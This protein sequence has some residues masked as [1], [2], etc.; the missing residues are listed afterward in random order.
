MGLKFSNLEKAIFA[1]VKAGAGGMA[2]TLQAELCSLGDCSCA[3]IKK[4]AHKAAFQR[5]GNRK[6]I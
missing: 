5:F 2:A 1:A 4:A 3:G 6:L